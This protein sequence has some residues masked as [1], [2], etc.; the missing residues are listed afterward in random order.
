M[1]RAVGYLID[2]GTSLG[3]SASEGPKKP[4]QGWRYD[5]D[6]KD[7]LLELLT[8][9]LYTGGCDPKEQVVSPAVGRFSPRLDPRRWKPY[10][11]NLAFEV[12]TH[13]DGRWMASKIATL[14]RAHLAAAV[15]AGHYQ[16]Q[17]DADRIL[18]I[19][20]ARRRAIMEAY[21]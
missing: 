8:L 13:A 6:V 7:G 10:A 1:S 9:G 18:D 16:N 3:A 21:L 17:A 20:E 15:A 14:S 5:V 4:C 2:F 12:M 11:P 19:L